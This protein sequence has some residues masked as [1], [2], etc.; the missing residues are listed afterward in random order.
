MFEN[1]IGWQIISMN[2]DGFVVTKDGKIRTFRFD[3]DEGCCCGYNDFEAKLF[4]D[5]NNC[6]NPVITSVEVT[7]DDSGDHDS[8]SITFFLGR[9]SPWHKLTVIPVVVVDGATVRVLPVPVLKQEK[10]NILPVIKNREETLSS[11]ILDVLRL[12]FLKN[13][14]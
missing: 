12:I 5:E 13:S 9:I 8:V 6:N 3:E 4:Y 10:R 11:L 2:N 14:N 7:K 1:L